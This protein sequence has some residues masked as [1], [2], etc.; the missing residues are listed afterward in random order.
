MTDQTLTLVNAANVLA[1]KDKIVRMQSA[2][3]LAGTQ[4][5]FY[6]EQHT[7]KGTPE[8]LAKAEINKQFADLCER[9]RGA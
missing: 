9:E 3:Q 4:F 5:R 8:S 2:L 6:A 7:A 1:L